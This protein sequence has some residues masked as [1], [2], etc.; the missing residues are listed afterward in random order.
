[1][2][3]LTALSLS[4]LSDR[5]RARRVSPVEATEAC[6]RR[7]EE[8]DAE[9]NSFLTVCGDRA[10]EEARERE[11][12]LAQGRW[13]GPLHGVP[14]ALKD[15]FL[16]AGIRTTAGSAILRDWVPDRHIAD[17]LARLAAEAT[18]DDEAGDEE[19]DQRG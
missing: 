9:L 2:S 19:V 17:G 1:M 12:E 13:R 16:T 14:I 8:R 4:D 10:L 11:A 15:L 3:P 7:I 18:A 5:I 6:L